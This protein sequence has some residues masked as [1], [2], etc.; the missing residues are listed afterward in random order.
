[1]PPGSVLPIRP[2]LHAHLRNRKGSCLAGA[3][4]GVPFCSLDRR[5]D[6]AAIFSFSHGQD[7]NTHPLALLLLHICVH[8]R[9]PIAAV[10][11]WQHS[12]EQ[13]SSFGATEVA[14]ATGATRC[15]S[16]PLPWSSSD[17]RGADGR[18]NPFPRN[19][20][21]CWWRVQKGYSMNVVQVWRGGVGGP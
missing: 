9:S 17:V 8:L 5:S 3:E 20:F 4:S 15:R 2:G 13:T 6:A 7:R 19:S 18:R 12:H 14:N 1:M 11:T 16:H 21:V 10:N